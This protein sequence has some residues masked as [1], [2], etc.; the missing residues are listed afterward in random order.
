VDLNSREAA[1]LA[2]LV[3]VTVAVFGMKATRASAVDVVKAFLAPQVFGVTALAAGYAAGSAWLL[4]HVAVWTPQNL[5]TT[6]FWFAGTAFITMMDMRALEKGTKTLRA[7]AKDAFAASAIVVFLSGLATFP[8]WIE[9]ILLPLLTVVGMMSV[10]AQGKP[11][12]A[13]LVGPLSAILST[14]GFALLAYS[15]YQVS[16]D[17]RHLD[18]AQQAREL[19]LPIVLTLTFLPFLYGLMLTVAYQDAAI[20]LGYRIEDPRVRRYAWIRGVLAF[21]LHLD[22]FKRYMQAAKV[23]GPTSRAEVSRIVGDLKRTA[24]RER[25]PP[26]VDPAD[27]WSP[28]DARDFL[29]AQGLKTDAYRRSIEE[30]WAESPML[31]I[32]GGIFPDRI[33]YRIYGTEDAATRLSLVLYVNTLE[34]T[35][36]ADALFY[37]VALELV[38]T[39]LGDETASRLAASIEQNPLVSMEAGNFQL[40]L[41]RDD[42]GAGKRAGYSR[43]LTIDHPAHRD[44][45]STDASFTA[46]TDHPEI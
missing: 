13:R 36:S 3:L 32:G 8:F 43:R 29:A 12:H 14:I 31:D 45:W 10:M 1:A 22:L 17:W 40:S 33:A 16:V 9:F 26:E 23:N 38:S 41:A 7:V 46:G 15:L 35:D 34:A 27:G 18:V 19:A 30:W 24:R 28:Y 37:N 6:V 21:G 2:W 42:W 4:A 39:A 25:C 44:P 20:G 11:E 5:K